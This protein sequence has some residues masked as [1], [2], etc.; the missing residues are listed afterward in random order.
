MPNHGVVLRLLI[1]LGAALVNHVR[2]HYKILV[3]LLR[4]CLALRLFYPFGCF[5]QLLIDESVRGPCHPYHGISLSCCRAQAA[6]SKRETPSP[7]MEN[8][9]KPCQRDLTP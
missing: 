6:A 4:R 1:Y 9:A 5:S 2:S 3:A 7:T 8:N